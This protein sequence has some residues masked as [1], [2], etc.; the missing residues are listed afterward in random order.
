MTIKQLIIYVTYICRVDPEKIGMHSV[1]FHSKKAYTPWNSDHPLLC[2]KH[3]Q[4]V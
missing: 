1:W 4:C 2:F 3:L